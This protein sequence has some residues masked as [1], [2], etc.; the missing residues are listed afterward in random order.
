M[1]FAPCN[2]DADYTLAV[3]ELNSLGAEC[4]FKANGGSTDHRRIFDSKHNLIDNM[5]AT[6]DIECFAGDKPCCIM[7]QKGSRQTN[8]VNADKAAGRSF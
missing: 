6:V 5:V 7:R 8:I 3:A 2:S 1:S 4:S